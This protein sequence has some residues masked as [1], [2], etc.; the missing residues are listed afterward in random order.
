MTKTSQ[1]E[2]ETENFLTVQSA[3]LWNGTTRRQVGDLPAKTRHCSLLMKV[4]YGLMLHM[5]SEHV[6]VA[7]V[8]FM[9]ITLQP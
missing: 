5:H 2:E 9:A 7:F 1:R 8:F 3:W 4:L 6:P